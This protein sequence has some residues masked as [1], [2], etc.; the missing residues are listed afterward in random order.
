MYHRKTWQ[1]QIPEPVGDVKEALISLGFRKIRKTGNG[2]SCI[3]KLHDDDGRDHNTSFSINNSGL[4]LCHQCGDHGNLWQLYER[5]TGQK[6]VKWQDTKKMLITSINANVSDLKGVQR[7][8]LPKEYLALDK[9]GDC[10]LYLSMRLGWDTIK[11]FGI[12][13]C[14]SGYFYNRI[15]IPVTNKNSVV[16][17]LARDYSGKSRLRYLNPP[18]FKIKNYIFNSDGVKHGSEL[19]IV[20]GAFNAMSMVE[21]GFTNTVAT[22]GTKFTPE[23]I[24]KIAELNP[25]SIVICFDRDSNKHKSGQKAA[26]KLAEEVHEWFPTFIMPLPFDKDPNDLDAKS[27][28]LCYNKKI[29]YEELKG[30]LNGTRTKS[31]TSGAINDKKEALQKIIASKKSAKEIISREEKDK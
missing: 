4:W 8:S 10:P 22:F 7:V 26:V 1:D 14:K 21:K 29:K 5:I 11:K 15:I 3:C 25:S 2:F 20:E 6:P 19:F 28:T 24:G 9:Q 16:G 31:T 18:E 13:I 27:L 17:F 12:G 23:Q 30:I